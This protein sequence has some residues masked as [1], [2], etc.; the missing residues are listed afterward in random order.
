MSDFTYVPPNETMYHRAVLL[1]LARAG[2]SDLC[3]ILKKA[4]CTI[5]VSGGTYSRSRWNALYTSVIFQI[6]MSEYESLSIDEKE[7]S[8]CLYAI[9]THE[10]YYKDLK[11]YRK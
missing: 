5:N 9:A 6:P 3:D 4:K 1:A 2:Q 8:V 11:R 7:K 10:G